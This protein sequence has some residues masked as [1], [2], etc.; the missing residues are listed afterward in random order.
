MG[1]AGRWTSIQGLVLETYLELCPFSEGRVRLRAEETG[2]RR[3]KRDPA[4]GACAHVSTLPVRAVTPAI[5][6]SW[7]PRPNPRLAPAPPPWS[8]P[9]LHAHRAGSAP[10]RDFP[11]FGTCRTVFPRGFVGARDPVDLLG[12]ARSRESRRLTIFPKAGAERCGLAVGE[13]WLQLP[14]VKTPGKKLSSLRVSSGRLLVC[15]KSLRKM[16]MK[17]GFL[18]FSSS[19]SPR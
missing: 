14:R 7:E 6:R 4:H 11:A 18:T 3:P 19:C 2:L 12:G 16:L 10:A 9:R 1:V 15:A 17:A 13:R 8:G 5:N